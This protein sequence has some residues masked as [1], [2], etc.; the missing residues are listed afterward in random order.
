MKFKSD[1]EVQAGL[2]DAGGSPGTVNQ[3]LSSTVTGTTWIDPSTIVA[4]AATVV[5]IACKNTS[6]ATIEKGTPV[7]QTGTVGA[8][9]TIEIAP[10]DALISADKL[11]A[12]GLLQTTLN[13][14]GLGFVVIT[15]ALTNF[16]TS[17]IDGV[18]P[19]TGDKVFVKSG[20]GL[21]L[22]KPTGDGNGIQN[23]GLVGK[24]AIGSAGSITVSSIMRTNDVPNLPTGRTWVGNSNTEVSQA[25][26]IDEPNLRLGI[27]TTAPGGKLE[28]N[29]THGQGATALIL[30]NSGTINANGAIRWQNNAGTNQAAIS[31]YYNVA[32]AGAIEFL[33]GNTT[34]VII[35]SSGNVGIGTTSPANKL[36]INAPNN[37]TA[38]GIDFPSAHFDFSANSTSGYNSRFHMDNVGMDIGHDSTARS[39][40]LI[41][42][43]V[44]RLVIL[45]NGNVGIGT[46]SPGAK[47][48]VSSTG[49]TAVRISTDG[50]AG[51]I[52]MLQLYRSGSSYG[53]M[54]YEASGGGSSG[55]HLTDFRDDT[56]S[57]IIFNTR[58]ANERMRIEGD[59][60][61]GI[62]TTAPADNLQLNVANGK[63]ITVSYTGTTD[64]E[65]SSLSFKYGGNNTYTSAQVSSI[66][67]AG[68]GGDLVLSS[69]NTLSSYSEIMRLTK[70]GNVGIGTTSPRSLLEIGGSGIL[71]SVTNKVISTIIDGGY[72]TLNSLQYNVN[73]FIG[74][75]YGTSDIFAQTSG[76]VLKNFYVGLVAPNSYFNGSRYSITQ[77]GVERLTVAQGGN[78]GIGTTTPS[79]KLQVA[80]GIQMADDTDTASAAKVGTLKYR[81][82]GN[83][84]YVDMCMQTGAATY[85][86]VNI[87]QNNW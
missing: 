5:V 57:H 11:P 30:R 73:A 8:T 77:G 80:G 71:G 46:T 53:Q 16:T 7:Y 21:T 23:M 61:V 14:N 27:G 58:G 45:G 52:P 85:E 37:T 9:A 38:V 68:G 4:E 75:S 74:T 47:L 81:V 15:G 86:W 13:N 69:G 65:G 20:G 24:V 64:G 60:N 28:I 48:Q 40:N 42:G 29:H 26:Y 36:T 18:V 3:L 33:N 79:S 67:R 70:E 62:G 10:A 82:S 12:I 87:V 66:K 43:N 54:H 35:R 83:N 32:D 50:D 6:G 41:T 19:T 55:L 31:S 17:P 56:N 22:T 49:N 44:D 51:D 63:G 78:V 76:E 25:I 72:S 34:N 1:I 84:S 39:L 2:K 59:G